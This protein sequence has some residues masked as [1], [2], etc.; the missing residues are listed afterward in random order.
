M[1]FRKSYAEVLD[2]S[3]SGG[4]NLK[5]V[6]QVAAKEG[7]ALDDVTY[8]NKLV[9]KLKAARLSE[10]LSQVE[11]A[12]ILGIPRATLSHWE[13]GRRFPTVEHQ[14]RISSWL[15]QVELKP[16]QIDALREAL[17][18][19]EQLKHLLNLL[20][21]HLRYFQN[22]LPEAR[23]TYRRE[24]NVY[25][26]GYLTSLL[27][28]LFDEG[29]FQRWKV[30]TTHHFGGFRRKAHARKEKDKGKSG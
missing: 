9:Q 22:E 19:C 20:E 2:S 25:D 13:I 8:N 30:F 3:M 29:K 1:G 6:R 27:E 11:L 5:E 7:M 23:E 16:V 28:M 24:L 14:Q 17:E 4:L 18:H 26:V 10:R 12:L 21:F 15:E